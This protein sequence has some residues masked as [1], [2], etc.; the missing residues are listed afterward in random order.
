MVMTFKAAW[1]VQSSSSC[2]I[3]S[4]ATTRHAGVK[5]FCAARGRAEQSVRVEK[6]ILNS[7]ILVG[8][9]VP[10]VFKHSLLVEQGM[11]FV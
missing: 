7:S 8:R 6:N 5:A 2:C 3:S 4:R 11:Q 10:H 1:I 9:E